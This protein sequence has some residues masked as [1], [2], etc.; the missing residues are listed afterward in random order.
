MKNFIIFGASKGLGEAFVKG[1]PE[2]GDHV[3]IVSRSRPD[4]LNLNNGVH[5]HWIEVDLSSSEASKQIANTLNGI[6]LDVLIYNVGIWESRGFTDDYNFEEDAP[7]EIANIVHVNVTSAITCI[8]KLLPN[9]K[10]SANGKIIL[11]GSTAGLD[12]SNYTQISFAA[13]KFALRGICNSLREHVKQDG[14]G[15]TCI[16]PG[17]IATQIPYEEGVDKVLA[18]HGGT[19][20]PLQDI[21][22]LVKCVINLSKASCVKEIHMPTMLDTNA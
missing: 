11:I 12:N 8:Q 2:Q 22:S 16:N 6:T 15:V 19:Q 5:K 14:I 20:I 7:E 18:A 13:S 9:L 10:Q 1:L 3:W 21:V 4:S 17:E